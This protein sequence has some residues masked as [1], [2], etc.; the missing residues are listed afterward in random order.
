MGSRTQM[1]GQVFIRKREKR[2][3][4]EN[5]DAGRSL[6]LVTKGWG[7]FLLFYQ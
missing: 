3:G 7:S 6:E 2:K 5:A 4:E 1:E